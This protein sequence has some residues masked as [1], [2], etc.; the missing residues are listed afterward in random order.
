M[1]SRPHGVWG[2]E[3][4]RFWQMVYD[5]TGSLVASGH[6]WTRNG[7]QEETA[8]LLSSAD[9]QSSS[10]RP[11]YVHPVPLPT[12]PPGSTQSP[13]TSQSSRAAQITET[14]A[15]NISY[16]ASNATTHPPSSRSSNLIPD[17]HKVAGGDPPSRHITTADRSMKY[18]KLDATYRRLSA[19]I[20]APFFVPG[21]VFQM[22]WTDPDEDRA[23]V[24]SYGSSSFDLDRVLE[25][26]S[27]KIRR[28]VV[29]K[30]KGTFSLCVPV[31]S[32]QTQVGRK[33]FAESQVIVYIGPS[34]T[35]SPPL[36]R[37]EKM[38]MLRICVAPDF[39]SDLPPDLHIDFQE[40][41]TIEHDCK[42]RDIG[43]VAYE[44]LHLLI[45]YSTQ[46]MALACN[47]SQGVKCLRT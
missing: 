4:D 31:Q 40:P 47:S 34:H 20:H 42:V 3:D 5:K 26:I 18:E 17:L 29:L 7:G 6:I 45:I 9:S 1:A 10:P 28:F 37:G 46:A 27:S 41:Y 23:L 36:L 25:H 38:D 24:E 15:S 22:L 2:L 19:R 33:P 12:G 16:L 11:S 32:Y 30:N 39:G 21:R 13:Q 8:S 35:Q 43:T 14:N 44:H